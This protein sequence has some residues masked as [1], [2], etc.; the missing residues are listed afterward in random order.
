MTRISSSAPAPDA[1]MILELAQAAI[2]DLPEPY[3][4]AAREVALRIEDFADDELL[5]A[6]GIADPFEL[7][8]LY[9]GVPLTEKDLSSPSLE[10]DQVFL[11]RRPIL[12]EWIDRA[13]VSLDELVTHV[14]V[15]ELAH[16]F[17]WTDTEI[18]KI[19]PWWE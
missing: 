14:V 17:G 19:D 3:R 15:H 7:T 13:N 18:A 1:Q 8:G 10:N 11:F 4:L 2:D 9:D 6:L 5:E 12:E 16:H